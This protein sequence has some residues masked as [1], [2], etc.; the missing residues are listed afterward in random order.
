MAISTEEPLDWTALLKEI[1]LRVTSEDREVSE[2]AKEDSAHPE[3]PQETTAT[4]PLS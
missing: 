2:E 3:V 4:Q 1:D